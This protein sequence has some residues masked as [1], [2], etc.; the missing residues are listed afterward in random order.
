MFCEKCGSKLIEGA[1]FCSKCGAETSD[2]AGGVAAGTQFTATIPQRKNKK[3]LW[4]GLIAV[5]LV[6]ALAGGG[7]VGSRFSLSYKVARQLDLG[8]RYLENLE[9]EEALIAFQK[10]IDI[11]PKNADAF[12]GLA[13]S[14]IGLNIPEE[15]QEILQVGFEVT[16]DKR[17]QI[18]IK[19]I[20]LLEINK[21]EQLESNEIEQLETGEGA[22]LENQNTNEKI[23]LLKIYSKR[24][25]NEYL[26]KLLLTGFYEYSEQTPD[27]SNLMWF[28][29][30]YC[31]YYSNEK[32]T[33]G[34]QY[35]VIS[36]LDV[37]E[38]LR[39]YFNIDAPRGNID[40]IKYRDGKF[41]FPTVDYGDIGRS[42]GITKQIDSRGDKEYSVIFYEIYIYPEDFESG[43]QNPIDDWNLYYGY[44]FE[45]IQNDKFCE[46]EG[47]GTCVL[48]EVDGRLV[49]SEFK[50]S[51]SNGDYVELSGILEFKDNYIVRLDEPLL[52][53]IEEDIYSFE[54]VGITGNS[55]YDFEDILGKH[56]SVS[57]D[58]LVAHSQYHY[59]PI[60]IFEGATNLKLLE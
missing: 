20:E 43:E 14:Y 7:V 19:E 52:V 39:F 18:K 30:F 12:L 35:C 47:I 32:I 59:S 15:A 46:V 41:Y 29:F 17:L 57:G 22:G 23:D 6:A 16:E 38:L 60:M 37:N 48:K 5:F 4:I 8:N 34:E 27:F 40:F 55:H 3:G 36:E 2:A 33:Y 53:T 51:A 11:D 56:V 50:C 49:I 13:D 9:Y 26:S 10:V 21:V 24:D 28:V 42:I 58:I 25:L 31:D 54:E 1:K 44:E 45:Q